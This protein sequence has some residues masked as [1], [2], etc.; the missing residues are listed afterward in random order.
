ML[1]RWEYSEKHE[2]RNHS[3]FL[4]LKNVDSSKGTGGI[5]QMLMYKQ[6][7]ARKKK[8]LDVKSCLRGHS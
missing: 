1:A 2:I 4:R 3:R 5:V 6:H 7:R 8:V